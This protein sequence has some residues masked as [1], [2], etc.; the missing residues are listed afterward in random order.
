MTRVVRPVGMVIPIQSDLADALSAWMLMIRC[1]NT[2]RAISTGRFIDVAAFR[3]TRCS[4]VGLTVRSAAR[5]TSGSPK[6]HGSAIRSVP[7]VKRCVNDK[8]HSAPSYRASHHR[9][10]RERCRFTLGSGAFSI[11]F[12][13]PSYR[14]RA[15]RISGGSERSGSLTFAL[16]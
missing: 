10:T 15:S 16:Y 8:W 1:P 6:M 7:N 5:P 9:T 14:R 4:S 3:S 11:R 13:T 2:G 12:A